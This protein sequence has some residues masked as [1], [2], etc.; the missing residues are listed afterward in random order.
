MNN[1]ELK[2]NPR[3]AL[4]SQLFKQTDVFE[5]ISSHTL[6]YSKLCSE[7]LPLVDNDSIWRHSR[8]FGKLLPEQG[9]KLH[10]SATILTANE[11]LEK[12]APFLQKMKVRFK[13]P[14][15]LADLKNL[16]AGTIHGY[17]QV[18]KFITVY[19][20][21]DNEAVSL[22]E[23]LH[24]LTSRFPSAPSVPFD[25]RYKPESCIY[26]R[27]GS[28][29]KRQI[30]NA[31]G[32]QTLLIRNL[33]GNLVPDLRDAKDCGKPEWVTNPFPTF[34]ERNKFSAPLEHTFKIFRALS[35]RGKGGV[36]QA[37]DFSVTPP[38]L[39]IVKEGRR[40]AEIDWDERDGFIRVRHEEK[41]LDN[42]KSSGIKAPQLYAS[43]ETE[44]SFY[45]VTEF[46]EGKSLQELLEES[47]RRLSISQIIRFG[48]EAARILT[49]I[50]SVGLIW[51]DLKPANLIIIKDGT[52]R[53]IDFEGACQ[54]R[55]PDLLPW[56]TRFYMPPETRRNSREYSKTSADLFALG[57][58]LYF[59]IEG[60]QLEMSENP[61]DF[62]I[63]RRNVP[64][65]LNE[66]VGQLLDLNSNRRPDAGTVFQKLQFLLSRIL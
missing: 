50:H 18:G 58:M 53:P 16:N 42:L 51:R 39:C 30:E 10:V 59:L 56:G 35:Q 19:P 65:E 57:S 55:K 26:Y 63:T 28:F 14:A 49:R 40:G 46:I 15:S 44:N 36:Y 9:W 7:F 22:A 66:I 43:F 54:I 13:A 23:R 1:V 61:A 62:K 32:S 34:T 38:R 12:V 41:I 33:S 37:V 8:R 4:K 27:Y 48:L 60:K 11:V 52:L 2:I 29:K 25:F 21:T 47:K 17:S 6:H 20:S 24:Q 64:L 45:I 3:T 31:D 5:K